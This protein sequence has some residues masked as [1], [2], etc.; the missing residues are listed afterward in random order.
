MSEKRPDA[1]ELIYDE[2]VANEKL[3]HGTRYEVL[4]AMVFK[5]L[6]RHERVV[7]D[8]RLRGPGKRTAH[9]IDVT[10]GRADQRE[11]RLVIECR[12]LFPTSKRPEI[13]LGAVRDVASVLRDLR[14]DQGLMLTT[15]GPDGSRAAAMTRW[16]TGCPSTPT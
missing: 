10:L 9:Q 8:L 2:F 11:L 7:H 4:A 14:P 13:R 5:S 16:M 6:N 12:H 15:A 3:K 1:I